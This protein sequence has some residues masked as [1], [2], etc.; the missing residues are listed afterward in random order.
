VLARLGLDGPGVQI[1]GRVTRKSQELLG[2]APG[3]AV[4]AQIKSVS[5]SAYR[6]S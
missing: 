4:H 3:A 1:V 6:S 5:M 2:L